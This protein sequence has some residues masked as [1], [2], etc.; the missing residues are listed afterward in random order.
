MNDGA[1]NDLVDFFRTQIGACDQLAHSNDALFLDGGHALRKTD[2]T[3]KGS[4]DTFYD[5]DATA[6]PGHLSVFEYGNGIL[7]L[8][9]FSPQGGRKLYAKP[10]GQ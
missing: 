6:D 9:L 8:L 4:A 3:N 7:A 5:G 2:P 1:V 10:A